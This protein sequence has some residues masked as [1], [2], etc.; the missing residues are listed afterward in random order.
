MKR[1]LILSCT[2][3]K[4]EDE[5]KLPAL[6]RYDGPTFRVVRKF[7]R[8]GN[9]V[10]QNV[11]IY[12]LSARYGLMSAEERVE[13]YDQRM[14][15]ARANELRSKTLEKLGQI[16]NCQYDEVFL[17]LGRSYMEAIASYESLV[18]E[19][20]KVIVSRAS[21]GKR[22]T[23]LKSW[24]YRLSE[25]ETR[26]TR[27]D[28]TVQVT[29]EAV[30]RGQQIEAT[31]DEVLAQAR[32]ALAEGWGKPYNFQRWYALVDEERVS[33][34]WL[35]SLLSGLEVSEFQASEARRVLGQLGVVVYGEKD[36]DA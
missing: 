21:A 1:C 25:N 29:G 13:N 11:D 12:V 23:E 4:R 33:T 20:T 27:G 16:F 5:G 32:K 14:T 35:A 8:E 6:E 24:L 30:L 18:P 3:T 15:T 34:K 36:D 9:Q 19:E 2:R 26:A 22:L 31:A 10:L 28:K 17:A 7:L